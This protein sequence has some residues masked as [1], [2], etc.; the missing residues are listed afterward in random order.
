[1]GQYRLSLVMDERTR[2][3]EEEQ[4]LTTSY[5]DW[6]DLTPHLTPGDKIEFEQF[7]SSSR[8]LWNSPRAVHQ[9]WALYEGILNGIHHIIHFTKVGDEIKIVSEPLET[10]IRANITGD[11]KIRKNNETDL[12]CSPVSATDILNFARNMCGRQFNRLTIRI[13]RTRCFCEEHVNLWRYNRRMGTV[14]KM[15]K[16]HAIALAM[17]LIAA[18]LSAAAIVVYF[19]HQPPSTG[20]TVTL[21][22]L[23]VASMSIEIAAIIL[24]CSSLLK[25]PIYHQ[26]ALADASL[27]GEQPSL[28][29]LYMKCG[30]QALISTLEPGDK[31]EF[32]RWNCSSFRNGFF[33]HWAIYIG[34]IDNVPHVIHYTKVDKEFKVVKDT[35]E[36][37]AKGGKFR[38][39]NQTDN[40]F[41]VHSAA[42]ILENAEALLH[43]QNYNLFK[44]NCEH[45]ANYCRYG[46]QFSDQAQDA[47]L[48]GIIITFFLL[49]GVAYFFSFFLPDPEP[50]VF[51]HG[52]R[53][54][55]RIIGFIASILTVISVIC[56]GRLKYRP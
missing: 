53:L 17:F 25:R 13:V 35:L 4:H 50:P 44:S 38:K 19:L 5:M 49:L 51:S 9:H 21:L 10:V 45:F 3:L 39:N 47:T 46:S 40:E 12:E 24:L 26:I 54:A 15:I 30:D 55:I 1:S 23:T 8:E 2:L 56:R 52:V 43:T 41:M 16:H 48:R 32:S 6:H 36:K 42:T 14:R 33:Q 29:S 22:V 28:K 7:N 31:I 11:C 20:S 34:N 37:A 27:E 18:V